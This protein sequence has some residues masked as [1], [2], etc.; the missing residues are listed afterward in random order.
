[1]AKN[2]ASIYNSTNDS[3]SLEQ[4]IYV[5]LETT[6]GQLIA[7]TSADFIYTI[8]G[9][10]IEYSQPLE[11]SPHK[12]GRHH[13]GSIK[14]K[15]ELSWTI[16]ML[17]NIDTSLG[18]A[19]SA[20]ID[21]G[22]RLLY[23]SLM[24]KEVT[25]SGA[26]YTSEDQPSVTFSIF[27]VGDKWAK[28]ARGCFV[29]GATL[30][31]PG[32]GRAQQEFRG[33]GAEAFLIGIGK[34]TI[35]NNAGNTITLQTGEGK[36]MQVGG[37]VMIIE[38][39]GTTRSADTPSGSPRTITSIAGDIITVGGAP[40]ADA[41]GSGTPVYLCYYE[42]ATRTA[43]NNPVTG[44]VGSFDISGLNMLCLRNGTVTIEN[45]HEAVNYCYGEDAL[46]GS[47]FVA[48]NR[49]TCTVSVEVNLNDDTVELYN[50]IQR[51]ESQD[52][53][54]ILGSASGRHLKIDLPNVEFSVPSISVPETGSIPVTYE[55]TAYVDS[56]AGD[57]LTIS[58]I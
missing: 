56:S 49:M 20:E 19:S 44:L 36:R 55:G 48:A 42:P 25:T 13:T 26:V 51:F 40:L 16:P 5:K 50:A 22:V 3:S 31:F 58:F 54:L 17:F 35:D 18:A 2:F 1:M 45:A 41:D 57:E 43:I 9:T 8:G 15:K 46:H 39:D 27:E 6:R 37:L 21:T 28:Q 24:G 32:D 12:S 34:S 30:T 4:D 11:S 47:Y 38:A 33:M 52:I 10:S 29:D 14:G 7:P 23:K 53:E